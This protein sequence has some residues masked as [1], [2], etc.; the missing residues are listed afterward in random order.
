M[1]TNK[2]PGIWKKKAA[3]TLTVVLATGV[4]GLIWKQVGAKQVIQKAGTD[5]ET[6]TTA[7]AVVSVKKGVASSAQD[8]AKAIAV[9]RPRGAVVGNVLGAPELNPDTDKGRVVKLDGGGIRAWSQLRQGSKVLL[10]DLNGEV[11]EGTVNLT[12]T[13]GGWIR[14]GGDLS[15]KHGTFSL[16]TNF[17][18]VAGQILLPDAKLGYEITMDGSDILLVERRLSSLVCFEMKANE[19]GAAGGA[20]AAAVPSTGAN[21]VTLAPILNTRPGAKG[22]IY[23]S[24]DGETVTDPSWNGGKPIVAARA[25]LTPAQITEVVKS[26]AEDFAPFDVTVTTDRA[27]YE[28]APVGTRMKVIV[29]PTTTAAPG[30]GGYAMIGS[31]RSAGK[32]FKSDIP[33]WVFNLSQK[34]AAETISH[35]VGHTLGLYHDG[36]SLRTTGANGAVSVKSAEYYSGHGGGTSVPTSWAPIM[37]SG[38]SVSLVQWS[39][40]EYLGA[41]NKQ[42]DIAV[43]LTQNGFGLR[44]EGSAAGGL[45]TLPFN[46]SGK[47]FEGTG[48][49]QR[50]VDADAYSFATTG[51][52]FSATVRPSSGYGNV[53]ERLELLDEAGKTLAVSDLPDALT[54]S[55]SL[56][57]NAGKYRLLVRP[58]ASGIMP[59]DGYATGYSAY[60]ALGGYQISGSLE[61]ALLIP[62]FSTA[63]S[64]A[65]AVGKAFSEKISVSAGSTL[66]LVSGTLPEGLSFDP[67]TGIIKGTPTLDTVGSDPAKLR[68]SATNAFGTVFLDVTVQIAKNGLPIAGAF[69][70]ASFQSTTSQAPWVGVLKKVGSLDRVVAESGNVPNGGSSV[71]KIASSVAPD[72]KRAASWTLMTF[73]WKASSEDGHDGVKCSVNG[74]PAVDFVTGKSLELSGETDWVKQTLRIDAGGTTPA[75]EFTYTKDANLSAGR[76]RV[77]VYVE[78]VGQP[79]VVTAQP[80]TLTSRPSSA[81]TALASARGSPVA[82]AAAGPIP[83]RLAAT[84]APYAPAL[85]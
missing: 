29:T 9:L 68:I 5:L 19:A 59:K 84:A 22:V 25:P 51:G 64:F 67:A 20:G 69:T 77:W 61:G 34:T 85:E 66:A 60:G 71:L 8:P 73:W 27:V 21:T 24:F 48:L 55:V 30:W 35:E 40:G 42:D 49:L 47:T 18:E 41:N 82:A 12:L 56:T 17:N 76:D 74:K 38:Y 44:A 11:I 15:S 70:G 31:W 39:K 57:L 26:V 36:L 83:T 33:C 6:L 23:A 37:G 75:I 28:A 45:K 4:G 43:I 52:T 80:P 78:G 2:N 79:P 81:V 54:A 1:K 3:A 32:G 62:V 50:S 65:G 14:I 10:P 72:P 13:E 58:A 46:A 16:H 7:P 63:G 53:D